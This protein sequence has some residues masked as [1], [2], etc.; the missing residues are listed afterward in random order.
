[1]KSWKVLLNAFLLSLTVTLSSAYANE[2]ASPTLNINNASIEQLEKISEEVGT[3]KTLLVM[4][5]AFRCKADRFVNLTI[6]KL[7][8]AVL[9][10]CEWAHDDYSLNVDN[11]PMAESDPEQENLF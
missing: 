2:S 1:M 10:H 7:P 11:L 9:K 5:G 8:K 4:C 3:D 6:K